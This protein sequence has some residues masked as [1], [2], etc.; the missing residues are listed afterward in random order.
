MKGESLPPNATTVMPTSP[1]GS[2]KA[3]P[4]TNASMKNP[5]IETKTRNLLQQTAIKI[6]PRM[7][8]IIPRQEG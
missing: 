3:L 6:S 7:H 5:P 1:S 2:Q 8:Y 4:T